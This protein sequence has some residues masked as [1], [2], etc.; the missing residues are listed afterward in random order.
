MLPTKDTV[1]V[2]LLVIKLAAVVVVL[3][4]SAITEVPLSQPIQEGVAQEHRLQL[5][6][7]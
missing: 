4:P 5:M 1:V 3:P 6:V 7:I 2:V